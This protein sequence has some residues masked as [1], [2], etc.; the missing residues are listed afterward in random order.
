MNQPQNVDLHAA[1]A[2]H[3]TFLRRFARAL[4]GAQASGD[5][6]TVAT[7]EAILADSS[8]FDPDLPARVSL[9]RTF[10]A[11]WVAMP[12]DELEMSAIDAGTGGANALAKVSPRA[13]QAFLLGALEEFSVGEIATIM[14]ISTA[15]AQALYE[16]GLQD[17]RD[18]ARSR[19]MIIEDEPIIA[20]DIESIV[21]GLGHESVGIADIASRAV[22]LA[23][24]SRPDLILADIQL[25]DGSSGIEAVREILPELPVPVIFI[26]AYPE[27]L[28][29]G[30]RPEPTFLITKPFKRDAVEAAIS[31]ALFFN[32]AAAI[33][34]LPTV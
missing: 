19:I 15:E 9:Y 17:M 13:R 33:E 23:L 32:S 24:D 16:T 21:T 31:Q 27:R 3:L 1:I 25:A 2:P 29:T 20:M 22:E 18:Q 5:R 30:E 12:N 11:V 8:V 14:S 10:C 28:L 7:L 34:D 26:T 6:F 4:T